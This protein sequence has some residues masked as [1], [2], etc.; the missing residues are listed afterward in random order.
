MVQPTLS[1][2]RLVIIIYIIM[3]LVL[4]SFGNQNTILDK[5]VLP[6]LYPPSY[7]FIMVW[8]VLFILFGFFLAKATHT[9]YQWMGLG[10]YALTLIWPVIFVYS[11]SF[12]IGFY[13]I[14]FILLLTIL[15]IIYTKSPWLLPQLIWITFATYLSYSL[16]RLN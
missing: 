16:Y 4:N 2:T 11:S 15:F 3:L 1:Q 7:I 12:M 5:A 10:F 13:Y 9:S 6:S 14:F 8:F